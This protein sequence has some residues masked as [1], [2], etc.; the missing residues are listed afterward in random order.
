MLNRIPQE[1]AYESSIPVIQESTLRLDVNSNG[2]G[3]STYTVLVEGPLS[4]IAEAPSRITLDQ[5]T[6]ALSI[7][8][9]PAGL[10]EEGMLVRGEIHLIDLDGGRTILPV[11]LTAEQQESGLDLLRQQVALGLCLMLVGVSLLYASSY[12]TRQATASDSESR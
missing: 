4:R 1:E 6:D 12:S 11:T 9:D 5:D 3:S 8:L 7:Q 2:H 10:L